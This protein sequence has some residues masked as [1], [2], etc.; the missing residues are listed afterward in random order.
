[1]TYVQF[2][3]S[4]WAA[5][6]W[7]SVNYKRYLRKLNLLSLGLNFQ[8]RVWIIEDQWI[9]QDEQLKSC[10]DQKMSDAFCFYSLAPIQFCLCL[11]STMLRCISD[12]L[13]DLLGGCPSEHQCLLP[14]LSQYLWAIV[15]QGWTGSFWLEVRNSDFQDCAV[16]HGSNVYLQR[17][18]DWQHNGT[19]LGF[20]QSVSWA[21]KSQTRE[22]W[23]KSAAEDYINSSSDY[24]SSL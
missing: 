6:Y 14:G 24:Q 7:G 8:D 13:A 17:L 2:Y 4:K 18:A 5:A 20:K 16:F 22:L 3:I 11:L 21:K 12:S 1:M 15:K 10:P 9:R 23:Q 19:V